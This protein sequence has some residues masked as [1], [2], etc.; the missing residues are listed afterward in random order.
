MSSPTFYKIVLCFSSLR[1]N[2]LKGADDS[3]ALTTVSSLIALVEKMEKNEV[4]PGHHL[5]LFLCCD[6]ICL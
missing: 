5:C 3:D 6:V 4:I 2:F 1:E